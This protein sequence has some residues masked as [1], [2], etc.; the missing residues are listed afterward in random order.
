MVG[1]TSSALVEVVAVSRVR[2]EVRGQRTRE[3]WSHN[4][5]NVGGSTTAGH[6]VRIVTSPR[7]SVEVQARRA[8]LVVGDASKARVEVGT[9]I[10]VSK[11]S[12]IT[13]RTCECWRNRNTARTGHIGRE[14]ADVLKRVEVETK[15]A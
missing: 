13:S 6:V 4:W 10:C 15:A 5:G 9:I 11:R 7:V 1:N 12:V 14:V 8:W 3:E 2:V